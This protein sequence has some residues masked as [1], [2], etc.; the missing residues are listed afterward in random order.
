M[1]GKISRISMAK[2]IFSGSV[3][4]QEVFLRRQAWL[5]EP[6]RP[7]QRGSK[8]AMVNF[9]IADEI[10]TAWIRRLGLDPVLPLGPVQFR[11]CQIREKKQLSALSLSFFLIYPYFSVF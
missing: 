11:L 6:G 10:S 1:S 2:R 5:H 8:I 7:H 3:A 9:G 4:F